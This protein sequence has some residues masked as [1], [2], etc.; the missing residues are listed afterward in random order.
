MGRSVNQRPKDGGL[1]GV[2]YSVPECTLKAKAASQ[3]K[4]SGYADKGK[5]RNRSSG[6]MY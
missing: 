3:K 5:K 2:K 1:K 4:C 6:F